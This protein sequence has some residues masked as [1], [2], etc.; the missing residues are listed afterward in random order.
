MRTK[1]QDVI[2]NLGLDATVFLR[3]ARMC[4]NMFLVLSV[5][6]CGIMIPVNIK[7]SKVDS[8]PSGLSAFTLMTPMYVFNDS[9][10]SQVA[11]AWAFDGIVCGFLWWTYRA[12]CRLRRQ[13]FESPEY[14]MSLHARTLLIRHIPKKFRT[15]EGLLRITDK[16]NPTTSIPRAAIGRNVKEL[17]ELFEEHEKAVK[18]LEEVLAKYFEK[19]DSLPPRRPLMVP[20]KRYRGDYQAKERDCWNRPKVDAIDYLTDRIRLLEVEIKIVRE[21]IDKRNAMSYGF[22]SFKVIEAAHMFA[23]AAR[24]SH[25]HNTTI[26][27]A[28]R[29][30]DLIWENLHLTR[31]ALRRKRFLNWLWSVALTVLYIVPNALIAI[32]LTDLSNLATLWKAFSGELGKHPKLWAAVQGIASPALTSLVY[33]ILPSIFRRLAT[34]AGDT[35][36]TSRE[37]HVIGRLYA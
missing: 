1:E 37:Q 3:F 18:M 33:L 12:M 5:L 2:G 36:K 30:N 15:D 26:T 9:L 24:R 32:F 34:R 35:T 16:V 4:R 27:L 11:C 19:P 10:W 29:P 8:A 13:Y 14:K 20:D 6:G 28:P 31:G 17:P 21:S 25:P 23:H 7:E 22:A